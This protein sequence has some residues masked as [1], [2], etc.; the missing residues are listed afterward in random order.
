[1]NRP[2]CP[3]TNKWLDAYDSLSAGSRVSFIS[4]EANQST[5][6]SHSK[7]LA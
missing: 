5:I 2:T 7:E 6:E 4:D 3:V 1:M